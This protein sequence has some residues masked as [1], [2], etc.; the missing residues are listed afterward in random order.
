MPQLLTKARAMQ[1]FIA[2]IIAMCLFGT[3]SLIVSA[4]RD[5]SFAVEPDYYAK[6]LRW[7]DAARQR[8]RN[9]ELGWTVCLTGPPATS[10]VVGETVPLYAHVTDRAGAPL[11]GATVTGESFPN[12][13]ASERARLVFNPTETP[14]DYTTSLPLSFHGTQ[15]LR[16]IVEHAGERFTVEFDYDPI[17]GTTVDPRPRAHATPERAP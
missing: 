16:L 6:S 12:A 14:G 5:K 8:E 15:H 17:A 4:L 13:R 2:G 9:R 1:C 7:D 3:G 11:A 10:G